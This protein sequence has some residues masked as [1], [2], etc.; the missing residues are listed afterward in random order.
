MDTVE[1]KGFPIPLRY[2]VEEFDYCYR[3][4][5]DFQTADREDGKPIQLFLYYS[6]DKE[7][8]SYLEAIR[9]AL[10]ESLSHEVDEC[11][12]FNGK[13]IFDPHDQEK[14]HP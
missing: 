4:Q 11:L 10:I 2:F 7:R 9:S 1:L 12:H 3:I 14:L 6:Y 13:R 5:V 8:Y